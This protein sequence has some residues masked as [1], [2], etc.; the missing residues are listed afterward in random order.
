MKRIE[1]NPVSVED[2]IEK[3]K[4]S[5]QYGF[6]TGFSPI[7]VLLEAGIDLLLLINNILREALEQAELPRGRR[8]N[9]GLIFSN[10]EQDVLG[11]PKMIKIFFESKYFIPSPEIVDDFNVMIQYLI[12]LKQSG[13]RPKEFF[14]NSS[15]SSNDRGSILPSENKS[16][17]KVLD[18]NFTIIKVKDRRTRRYHYLRRTRKSTIK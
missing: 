9:P 16:I 17:S 7:D 1:L 6:T 3:L 8:I 4:S 12:A 14:M 5:I 10:R 2:L 11:N 18:D 13:L 15:R